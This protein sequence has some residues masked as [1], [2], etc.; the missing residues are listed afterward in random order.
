MPEDFTEF[1]CD[2]NHEFYIRKPCKI[3][4]KEIYRDK[5]M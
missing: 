4:I 1:H 5:D 2:K 3:Y